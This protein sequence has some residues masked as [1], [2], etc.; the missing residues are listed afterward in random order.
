MKTEKKNF[1]LRCW[2]YGFLFGFVG[3]IVAVIVSII[4]NMSDGDASFM[5]GAFSMIGYGAAYE[6]YLKE[7]YKSIEQIICSAIWYKE[8]ELK[9]PEVLE[10]RGY[11]PF[12]VDKGIVFS[13]LRHGN[14]LYQ[15]VAITGL[16]SYQAGEHEEGFLTNK[17]RFVDRKEA[18]QIALKAKQIKKLKY[19]KNELDSGDLF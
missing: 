14:C 10:G 15:M 2:L 5:A 8:L 7:Y 12:N 11:R 17:N 9:K 13:G 16:K 19:F 3:L 18:A 4:F 6:Y 1:I